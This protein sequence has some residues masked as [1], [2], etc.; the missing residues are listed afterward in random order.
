VLRTG[1]VE[2]YERLTQHERD[3]L[4]A[5]IRP[6]SPGLYGA[7]V[8]AF[9][10]NNRIAAIAADNPGLEA[11]YPAKGSDISLHRALIARLRMLLGE[12]WDVRALAEDCERDGR[13][14]FFLTSAPLRIGGGVGSPP[15]VLALK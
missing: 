9:L 1:W 12:L 8:S 5:Q 13:A 3:E 7:D 15:N 6:G 10:W 11:G 4:A 14:E 2:A